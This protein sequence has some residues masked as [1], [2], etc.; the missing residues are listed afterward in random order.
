MPKATSPSSPETSYWP[1]RTAW[2]LPRDHTLH[3]W[4]LLPTLHET[5]PQTSKKIRKIE[6]RAHWL[7]FGEQRTCDC[8]LDGFVERRIS[9]GEKLFNSIRN[10]KLHILHN[11]T[12]DP[13]PH[14][15]RL[16]SI[17]CRTNTHQNFFP[18]FVSFFAL[19]HNQRLVT[20]IPDISNSL[21][22][23]YYKMWLH[24]PLN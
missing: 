23:T 17:P 16:R 12:P 20:R 8:D 1:K 2:R 15:D 13:L 18:L 5:H 10:N 24:K 22:S 6:R 11:R 3:F 7:I 14:H 4:L 21:P 19:L 9:I